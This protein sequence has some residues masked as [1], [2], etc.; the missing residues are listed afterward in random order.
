MKQRG[1]DAGEA[2]WRNRIGPDRAGSWSESLQALGPF[3][4]MPVILL[5]GIILRRLLNIQ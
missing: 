2:R 3:L 4:L 5:L 1:L